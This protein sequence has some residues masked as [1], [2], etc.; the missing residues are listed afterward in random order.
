MTTIISSI[1]SLMEV[2]RLKPFEP[3]CQS[4]LYSYNGGP[5]WE[6]WNHIYFQ[7]K[8]GRSSVHSLSINKGGLYFV[9]LFYMV[10]D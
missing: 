10:M 3:D 7:S 2:G 1:H 9:R 8:A 5:N 4:A 6:P